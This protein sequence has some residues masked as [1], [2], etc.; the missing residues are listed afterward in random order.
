M[1]EREKQAIRDD[2]HLKLLRIGYLVAGGADAL[3]ALF[4]LIYVVIG[5]VITIGGAGTAGRAGEPSPAV[6][7]L[8]FVIIGL[9]VSFLF[10]AQAALK[11]STARAIGKR[12]S[13]TMC[14]IAAALSCLQMP[15]GTFL[16]VMTFM[17]LGRQSVKDL[18]EPSAASPRLAAPSERMAA[19]L[20]D[21]EDARV[22]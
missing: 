19:S 21:E 18:F 22:P 7:G 14:M 2:E 6:F 16:G 9:I 12:Q 4:P 17:V 3:F 13:R 1:T 11:L 5:I 20:F 15:W 10:A 8:I